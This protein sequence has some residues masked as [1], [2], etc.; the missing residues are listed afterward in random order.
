[1]ANESEC[2]LKQFQNIK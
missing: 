2:K 1:M